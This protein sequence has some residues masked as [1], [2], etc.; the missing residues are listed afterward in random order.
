MGPFHS[1]SVCLSTAHVIKATDVRDSLI[2]FL[3]LPYM[4][5]TS[6]MSEAS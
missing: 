4:A 6:V 2:H 1:Q 5:Q 3:Q